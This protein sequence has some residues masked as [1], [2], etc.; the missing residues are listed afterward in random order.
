[1]ATDAGVGTLVLSHLSRIA[2]RNADG[3]LPGFGEKLAH[4][5]ST[6]EGP[7]I[8]AEDLMCVPVEAK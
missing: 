1:M 2:P 7:M 4:L 5:R 8:I 3:D 6:Y